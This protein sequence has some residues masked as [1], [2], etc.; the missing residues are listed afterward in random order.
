MVI[1]L[2]KNNADSIEYAVEKV[3]KVINDG[4]VVILMLMLLIEYIQ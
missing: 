4:G 3:A 1:E 2:D